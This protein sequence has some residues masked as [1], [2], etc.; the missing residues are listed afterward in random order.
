MRPLRV[1]RTHAGARDP[2]R[3][4]P[5]S[6]PPTGRPPHGSERGR[7]GAARPRGAVEVDAQ[8][9]APG[10]EGRARRGGGCGRTCAVREA[11]LSAGKSGGVRP[12]AQRRPHGA[13]ARATHS[14]TRA[15]ARPQEAVRAR[16]R[17]GNEALLERL[18]PDHLA[19]HH[20]ED[21]R[22][23]DAP[24]VGT[25]DLD[26]VA[27]AV[28]A[29]ERLDDRDEHRLALDRDHAARA[30]PRRRHRPHA[31]PRAEVE[32][33]RRRGARARRGPGG[34]PGSSARRR[35]ASGGRRGG[36]Q[37]G[38]GRLGRA[39]P[40]RLRPS[41]Q[42]R[43]RSPSARGACSRSSRV[44]ASARSRSTSNRS[45]TASTTRRPSCAPSS[46]SQ[47][48]A[49]TRLR[50]RIES[51]SAPRPASGHEHVLVADRCGPPSAAERAQ[52][53]SSR[54]R[55]TARPPRERPRP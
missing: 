43:A 29:R 6:R 49:A 34:R 2:R 23:P 40:R 45:T 30:E 41:P 15:R 48:K 20:V 19:H 14:G 37:A 8:Q 44:S 1:E 31:G 28:L 53:S 16:S 10:G 38:E 51:R 52:T 36:L 5:R 33:G 18:V 50:L 39:R 54:G 26:A 27:D 17:M 46:V 55:L 3:P 35:G 13:A 42:R 22:E 11:T 9:L 25:D 4:T 32:D 7:A 24:R 12:R 21:A 47:T